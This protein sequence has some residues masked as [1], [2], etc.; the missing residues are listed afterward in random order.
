[1]SA[2][3]R[4][5][6]TEITRK[7]AYLQTRRRFAGTCHKIVARAWTRACRWFFATVFT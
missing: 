3:I 2:G 6:H 4:P 7:Y 5:Q 1:M